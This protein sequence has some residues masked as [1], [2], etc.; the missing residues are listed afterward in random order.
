MTGRYVTSLELFSI[1]Y[2]DLLDL[3][4]DG[5]F[6]AAV[7]LEFEDTKIIIMAGDFMN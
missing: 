1:A 2:S 4:M 3:I 6:R 7:N 5:A